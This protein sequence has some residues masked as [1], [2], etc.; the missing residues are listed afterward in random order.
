[1]TSVVTVRVTCPKCGTGYSDQYMPASAMPEET[2]PEHD[3]ADDCVVT[4]CPSCDHMVSVIVQM[5]NAE[6]AG[7]CGTRGA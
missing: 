2:G 3:Y 5:K 4:S 7:W 1:M 6:R